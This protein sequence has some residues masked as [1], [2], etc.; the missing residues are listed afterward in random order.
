MCHVN[1]CVAAVHKNSQLTAFWQRY[2]KR[3]EQ[4]IIQNAIEIDAE[5]NLQH[6]Q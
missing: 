1:T 3:L 5:V 6:A 2:Y 4:L